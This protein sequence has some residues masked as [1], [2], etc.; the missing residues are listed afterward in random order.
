MS[1]IHVETEHG[2]LELTLIDTTRAHVSTPPGQPITVRD[3]PYAFSADYVLGTKGWE[4]EPRNGPSE[5]LQHWR[6]TSWNKAAAAPSFTKK[7]IETARQ[8]LDAHVTADVRRAA[9]VGYSQR[10]V[11]SA[12]SAAEA[13]LKAFNE[14]SDELAAAEAR[15]R[16]AEAM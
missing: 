7:V 6:F 4:H 8:T 12:K 3:K 10:L 14:A 15:L 5:P 1:K 13:A 9:E 11:A 16:A 2:L